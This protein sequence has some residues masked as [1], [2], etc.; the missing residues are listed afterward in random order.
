MRWLPSHDVM[1]MCSSHPACRQQYAAFVP[2]T[3][4]EGLICSS[5]GELL[6]GFISNLFILERSQQGLVVKTAVHG[7]LPGIM[8]QQVLDACEALQIPV[9]RCPALQ[10]D[11]NLWEEAFLSNAVRGVRPIGK[12][13]CAANNPLGWEPWSRSFSM[14]E[15]GSVCLQVQRHLQ[16]TWLEGAT[17]IFDRIV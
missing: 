10:A 7:V 14:P 3:A 11:R 9:Q 16:R 2:D 4:A 17:N 12:I 13:N 6:E 1:A 5:Q 8:Q 15:Q